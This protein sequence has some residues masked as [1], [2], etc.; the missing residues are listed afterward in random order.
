VTIYQNLDFEKYEKYEL[1][2]LGSKKVIHGKNS[3]K[4]GGK[5]RPPFNKRMSS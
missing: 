4:M 1:S 5:N 3:R 2:D